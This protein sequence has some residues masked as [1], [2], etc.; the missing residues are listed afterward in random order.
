MHTTTTIPPVDGSLPTVVHL[1]DFHAQFNRNRPWLVFPSSDGDTVS[2]LSFYEMV[3]ASH[4]VA[5]EVRPGRQ[6]KDN[7][8]IAVLLNTDSV[9][10]VVIILGL[11]RAGFVVREMYIGFQ[12]LEHSCGYSCI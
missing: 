5:H 10:Y 4:R 3:E 11:L 8:V 7:E 6:G 9:V 12:S 1:A 2:C